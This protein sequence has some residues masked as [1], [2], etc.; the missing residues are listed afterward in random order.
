MKGDQIGTLTAHPSLQE[1][2]L[3][4]WTWF[5]REAQRRATPAQKD[6]ARSGCA[7]EA[8]PVWRGRLR[9]PHLAPWRHSPAGAPLR[10]RDRRPDAN[11]GR[12]LAP[13]MGAQAQG[14]DRL[15]A[16][17]GRRRPKARGRDAR[18][19][20]VWPALR[21]NGWRGSLRPVLTTGGHSGLRAALNLGRRPEPSM[22]PL[23]AFLGC[24][25]TRLE[26]FGLARNQVFCFQGAG[27]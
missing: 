1:L 15:Q 24:A 20:A 12:E 23:S 7:G 2:S 19:A 5:K 10:G 22:Q 13:D 25:L 26:R 8:L 6:R 21:A 18:H 3:S 27:G 4:N 9:R 14:A 11:L 16:S 17:R